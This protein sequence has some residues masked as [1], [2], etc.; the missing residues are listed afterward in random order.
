MSDTLENKLP[1]CLQ[2]HASLLEWRLL[3]CCYFKYKIEFDVQLISLKNV[4][5]FAAISKPVN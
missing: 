3:A 4:S 5:S 1:L 2:L